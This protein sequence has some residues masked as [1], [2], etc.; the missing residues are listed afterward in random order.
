MYTWFQVIK[1]VIHLQ[2]IVVVHQLPEPYSFIQEMPIDMKKDIKG[3][4]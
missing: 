2:Q 4:K 3:I 1:E